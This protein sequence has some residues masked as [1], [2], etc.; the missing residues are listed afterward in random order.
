MQTNRD[1]KNV[2]V[3]ILKSKLFRFL[4]NLILK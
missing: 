2:I 3:F 4:L 1:L